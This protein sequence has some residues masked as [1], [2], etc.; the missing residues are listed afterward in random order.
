M[1]IRKFREIEKNI[2]VIK[3]NDL[4]TKLKLLYTNLECCKLCVIK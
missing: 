3:F 4:L 2:T 1:H